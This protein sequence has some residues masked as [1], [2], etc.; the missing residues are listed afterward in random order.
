MEDFYRTVVHDKEQDRLEWAK[1]DHLAQ[2]A[3]EGVKKSPASVRL[4][5]RMRTAIGA[6]LVGLAAFTLYANRYIGLR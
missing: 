3:T 4:A 2:L 1:Q 6:A 5:F